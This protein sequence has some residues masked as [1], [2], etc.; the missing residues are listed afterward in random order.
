MELY[1]KDH[2]FYIF[3]GIKD[4]YCSPVRFIPVVG[5]TPITPQNATSIF[6]DPVGAHYRRLK[7]SSCFKT[8]PLAFG[9][10]I[11]GHNLVMQW[12]F[13]KINQHSHW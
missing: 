1:F 7:S 11:V 4:G 9:V 2:F 5:V 10:H 13:P 3:V 8:N 6:G 12:L